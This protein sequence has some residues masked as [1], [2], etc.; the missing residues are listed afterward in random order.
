MTLR[1]ALT[2]IV[3][4]RTATPDEWSRAEK[5]LGELNAKRDNGRKSEED[6]IQEGVDFAVMYMDLNKRYK[7]KSLV[8]VSNLTS[9]KIAALLIWAEKGGVVVSD[10]D[11]RYNGSPIKSYTRIK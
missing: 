10:N 8:G 3:A 5:T 6:K 2:I 7:A 1:E 11:D 4:L 9:Q